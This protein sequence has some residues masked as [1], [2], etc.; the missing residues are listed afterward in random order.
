[1][2]TITIPTTGRFEKLKACI[3][4]IP[5]D[6]EI[7]IL[8]GCRSIRED[9]PLAF[10]KDTRI[11]VFETNDFPVGVQNMLAQEIIPGSHLLPISDDIIFAPKAIETALEALNRHF[12]DGHGIVGFNVSNLIEKYRSPYSYMLISSEFLKIRLKGVPF[13]YK[14]LHF[15]AD[16]DLGRFAEKMGRFILCKEA[17]VIHYHPSAGHTADKTHNKN[18][19]LKWQYDH[20][21][22]NERNKEHI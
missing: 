19:Q 4:S 22:F 15:F 3:D 8:I 18:R 12:P 7:Q 10:L 1:M 5:K 2:I 9:I 14:Y 11:K 21:L 20:D 17:E 6:N 13:Y 16:V